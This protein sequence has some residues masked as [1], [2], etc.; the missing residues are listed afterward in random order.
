MHC[1]AIGFLVPFVFI[2]LM[3]PFGKNGAEALLSQ[4]LQFGMV[5]ITSAIVLWWYAE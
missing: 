4:V 5:G 2:L 3:Q 1:A